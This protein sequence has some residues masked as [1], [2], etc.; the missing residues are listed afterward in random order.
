MEPQILV[1]KRGRKPK[2]KYIVN[3]NP[4]FDNNNSE[5]II[6]N[7]KKK[8]TIDYN[9]LDSDNISSMYN[10]DNIE[11]KIDNIDNIDKF[12]MKC[13]CKLSNNYTSLPIKYI[14]D[15]FYLYGNFC[16]YECCKKYT[17][18]H[19]KYNKYEI[20]SYINL[21][22]NYNMKNI[23]FKIINDNINADRIL[24]KNKDLKLYRTKQDKN[25]I[26]SIINKI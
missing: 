18:M 1:K 22:C 7:I 13:N 2:Q 21:I 8:K 11:D 24:Y 3:D 12:C 6:I 5:Q 9:I 26:L 20:Y 4:I 25:N 15:V 10:I 14:N 23:K 16:N 17:L 19:Y